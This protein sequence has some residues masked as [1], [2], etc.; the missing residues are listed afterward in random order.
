MTASTALARDRDRL[1]VCDAAGVIPKIVHLCFG[2]APDFGGKPWSLVHYA[3]VKSMVERLKPQVIYLY[4]AYE[5][6]G[7]WWQLTRPLISPMRIAPPRAIFGNPLIHPAHRADIVR[8]EKLIEHGGIYLDC[9]VL[10]MRSFDS[11]LNSRCVLGQQGEGEKRGLCNGVI[12]AEPNARFLRRW[13]DTYRSFRSK[14]HDDFWSEHSVMMPL[15]L[16]R[17]DASDLTVLGNRAFHWP[18]FYRDHLAWTYASTAPIEAPDAFA[19]HLWES[20]AWTDYLDGLTVRRVRGRDTNFH[21]WVRP[22]LAE[23]PDDFA[24][25]PAW[26]SARRAG[27]RAIGNLGEAARKLRSIAKG[28]LK[29][30][31]NPRH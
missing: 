30:V 26:H 11:L 25:E 6:S 1:P 8:L 29:R 9:D 17:E 10:V 15:R 23:L 24:P 27:Q 28:T 14:G 19:H 13:Y 31:K 12:L 3:C 2:M 7:P 16:A 5:P 4:Y 18:M 21:R 20:L 22:L